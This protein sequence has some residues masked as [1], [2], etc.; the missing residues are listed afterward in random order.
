M[1]ISVINHHADVRHGDILIKL[2]KNGMYERKGK[3]H[4]IRKYREGGDFHI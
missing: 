1:L 2:P 3:V 4:Y